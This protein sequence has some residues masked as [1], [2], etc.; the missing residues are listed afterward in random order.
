MTK[1]EFLQ[2]AALRL[3]TSNPAANMADVARWATDLTER[4]FPPLLEPM[5]ECEQHDR[6]IEDDSMLN[7]V[8][9]IKYKCD[10]GGYGARLE[11]V[12]DDN[13]I[14]TVGDLLRVGRS[15]FKKY[16]KIGFG[17]IV[18]IDDALKD[19]YNIKSW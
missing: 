7:I 13:G 5:T 10:S 8:G 4:I 6:N 19:L 3:I 15:Q 12:F 16:P 1:E 2:E 11:R 18:R 9:Y 17:S 14:K